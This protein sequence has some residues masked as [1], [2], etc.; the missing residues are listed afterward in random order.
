MRPDIL[1]TGGTGKTGRQIAR[2]L[3]DKGISARIASRSG[4]DQT[5]HKGMRFDWADNTTFEAALDGI[6]AVYLVAPQNTS[7]L[8]LEM[9]PFLEAALRQ[10]VIRYVLLSTSALD[11][12]GPLMGKV[13]AWLKAEVSEWAVLR[14]SWF[15]Q[16]LVEPLQLAAI[17]NNGAIYSA[18]GH[19]R[20]GFIDTLDIAAVA[21]ALLTAKVAPNSDFV[22]TGP[23]AISYD[24]VASLVSDQLGKPVVHHC[25][26]HSE[27]VIRWIGLGLPEAYAI[28]LTDMDIAIAAGSEDHVTDNVKRITNQEPNSFLSF[29]RAQPAFQPA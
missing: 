19:G 1:I 14:P 24:E 10:G 25:L 23:E 20:I 13:H 11:E 6:S 7:E 3:A 26:S 4:K 8:L 27:M 28:M 16:N 9:Q 18:T 5:G 29:V 22:L 21:I 15:M 2:Q 12:G 17:Q